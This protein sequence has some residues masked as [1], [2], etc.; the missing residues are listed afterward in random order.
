MHLLFKN[1]VCD[2][3]NV[4]RKDKFYVVYT[5]FVQCYKIFNVMWYDHYLNAD[6]IQSSP[7]LQWGHFEAQP[8]VNPFVF[9]VFIV[10]SV[11]IINSATIFLF[12]LQ[13]LNYAL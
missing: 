11:I 5:L 1:L 8:S 4:G 2:K 10:N 13:Y 9:K 3:N 7:I 12:I 6:C